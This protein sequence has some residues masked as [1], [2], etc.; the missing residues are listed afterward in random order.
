MTVMAR[1]SLLTTYAYRPALGIDRIGFGT[2]FTPSC[3]IRVGLRQEPCRT[4]SDPIRRER[5]DQV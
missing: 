1:A 2:V 3:R 5:R 4:V